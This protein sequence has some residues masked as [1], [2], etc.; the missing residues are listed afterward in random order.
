[1][2]LI[3]ASHHMK[4]SKAQGALDIFM[5]RLLKQGQSVRNVWAKQPR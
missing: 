4:D 3:T 5:L 2:C 1:M